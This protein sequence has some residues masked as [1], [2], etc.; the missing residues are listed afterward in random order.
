[1]SC[2]SF[3][4]AAPLAKLYVSATVAPFVSFNAVQNVTTYRVN[5]EDIQRGYLDLPN[6]ITVKVKTNLGAGVPV[7]VENFGGA[8][9]LIKESGRSVFEGDTFTVN[10]GD[11]R[12]NT[13]ISKNYDSRIVLTADA[14]EGDY[15]LIISMTPSI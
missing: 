4:H 15:P 8:R 1:L 3:C 12:S 10:T 9:V 14:K 13:Q 2:A 5:S 7:T 6:A 11:Y